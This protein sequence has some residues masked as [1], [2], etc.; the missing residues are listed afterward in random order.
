VSAPKKAAL[1]ATL[2]GA[3]PFPMTLAAIREVKMI[4]SWTL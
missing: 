1:S 2:V 4:E 3:D